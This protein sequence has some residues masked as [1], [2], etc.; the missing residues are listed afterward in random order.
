MAES[1]LDGA[2]VPDEKSGRPSRTFYQILEAFFSPFRSP[3]QNEK[4]DDRFDI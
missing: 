2:S 1:S 3:N 4:P